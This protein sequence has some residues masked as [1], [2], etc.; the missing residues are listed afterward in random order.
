MREYL[1]IGFK[2]LRN[3]YEADTKSFRNV[4]VFTD[5]SLKINYALTF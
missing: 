3:G 2:Q 4:S 5:N 1:I